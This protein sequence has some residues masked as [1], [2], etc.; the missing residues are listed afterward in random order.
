MRLNFAISHGLIKTQHPTPLKIRKTMLFYS[1]AHLIKTLI[2]PPPHK[3][4]YKNIIFVR[5]KIII[6]ESLIVP[7]LLMILHV[8]YK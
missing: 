1:S 8:F 3:N 2:T 6:L 7:H 4:N 5:F